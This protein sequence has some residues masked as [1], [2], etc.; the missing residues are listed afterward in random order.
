MDDLLIQKSKPHQTTT[1]PKVLQ[2]TFLQIILAATWLVQHS[3][4]VPQSAATT[5]IPSL[6]SDSSPMGILQ[7][8]GTK[9]TLK[10]KLSQKLKKILKQTG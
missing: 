6:L 10:T 8:K 4:Y 9:G 3:K 2:Q 7:W 1:L 5:F